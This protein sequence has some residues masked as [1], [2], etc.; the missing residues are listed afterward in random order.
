M[1]RD[2][3]ISM[4][5]SASDVRGINVSSIHDR[6][7]RDYQ[8]DNLGFSS[9]EKES[10]EKY[11]F[12]AVVADGM[13]GLSD[14]AQI[15]SYVVDSVLEM[16]QKRDPSFPVHIHFSKAFRAINNNIMKNGIKG[17]STAAAVMCLPSGVHWCA[18][19][20]SRIYLFRNDF[21]THL[22]EDSDYLNR[23][24]ERVIL[25]EI[26]YAEAAKDPK[27]DALAQYMGYKEEIT[28]DVNIRPLV[29][30][31][32]DKLLICSDGVYNAASSE[33][34][35]EALAH[36]AGEA[37]EIIKKTVLSKGY[38]NQDNFTAVVLEF[39]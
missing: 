1:S 4:D 11:G 24:I 36:P 23:L 22:N 39:V 5:F 14:G 37:A 7:A 19:G 28:P 27:K 21:L 38:S 8:E 6:G 2:L 17:G 16:Q 30:R 34:L 3:F 10:L 13:G 15:S 9:A 26:A 33:E 18:V 20:D 25:H 31:K 35:S 12:T 32:N 29:P